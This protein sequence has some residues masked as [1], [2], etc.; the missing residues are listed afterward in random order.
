VKNCRSLVI[1]QRSRFIS[2]GPVSREVP[3]YIMEKEETHGEAFG[4][5]QFSVI[6]NRKNKTK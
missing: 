5:K 3:E 6:I 4:G 1:Q 2:D